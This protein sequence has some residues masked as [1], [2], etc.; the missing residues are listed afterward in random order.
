MWKLIIQYQLYQTANKQYTTNF[1]A[2]HTVKSGLRH[3]REIYSRFGTILKLQLRINEKIVCNTFKITYNIQ[4][5]LNIIDI[6][7]YWLP[8]NTQSAIPSQCAS[9]D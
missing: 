4:G 6:V 9:I 5:K 7:R 8:C 3:S 2:G 1:E